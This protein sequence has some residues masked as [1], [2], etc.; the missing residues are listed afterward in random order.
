MLETLPVV[1]DQRRASDVASRDVNQSPATSSTAH[2]GKQR[3]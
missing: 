1:T 3:I 2:T